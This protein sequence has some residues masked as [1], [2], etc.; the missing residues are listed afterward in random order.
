MPWVF[1]YAR[2]VDYSL[3]WTWWNW[4]KHHCSF[5]SFS[6]HKNLHTY[7]FEIQD[8]WL[9]DLWFNTTFKQYFNYIVAVS[10]IGVGNHGTSHQEKTTD[11]PQVTDNLYHIMLHQIHLAMSWTRTHSF[12]GDRPWLQIKVELVNPTT[13]WS[14]DSPRI[15]IHVHTALWYNINSTTCIYKLQC[16][17][18]R[19]KREK[20]LMINNTQPKWCRIYIYIS[21]IQSM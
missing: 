6:F 8:G 14:C 5:F 21:M 19:R 18:H 20:Q 4:F 3:C 13:I 15:Y 16:I 9:V 11:L 2:R 10:F 7:S 12:S 1:F 17:E